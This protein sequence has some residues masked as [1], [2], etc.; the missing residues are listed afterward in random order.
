MD[1]S[2]RRLKL[3]YDYVTQYINKNYGPPKRFVARRLLGMVDNYP[4][5]I[6]YFFNAMAYLSVGSI[7]AYSFGREIINFRQ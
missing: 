3:S 4:G 1:W 5:T 2:I 7:I 6:R